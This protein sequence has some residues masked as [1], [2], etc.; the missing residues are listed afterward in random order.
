M[1]VNS[2][3]IQ[4]ILIQTMMESTPLMIPQEMTTE[5][6][7]LHRTVISMRPLKEMKTPRGTITDGGPNEGDTASRME[8]SPASECHSIMALGIDKQISRTT[9]WPRKYV[10]RYLR[11]QPHCARMYMREEDDDGEYLIWE[12]SFSMHLQYFISL[13]SLE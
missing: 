7:E 8:Y 10:A 13:R 9:P 11:W 2:S 12:S 4:Q 6:L 5:A 3:K 1:L